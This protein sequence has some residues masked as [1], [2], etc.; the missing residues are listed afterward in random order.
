MINAALPGEYVAWTKPG[1]KRTEVD[2]AGKY[3]ASNWW[4]FPADELERL[5]A[6]LAILNNW[7]SAHSFPLN[8]FQST[9]R[10][11]ARAIYPN[12][13]VAQRIKRVP[14]I[15]LKLERFPSM[16]LSQMQDI[17]G[18][19]AIVGSVSNTMKL[20]DAYLRSQLRHTLV[21][22][23]DYIKEPKDSGY[24]GIHLVYRYLSDRQQGDHNGLQIEMQLRSHLQHAWATAVETAGT[25]LE[26][27]LKSSQG[28][29]E[30]LQFFALV[31]SGFALKEKCPPVPG[32]PKSPGEVKR[33]IK[34]QA[35]VLQVDQNLRAF[36]AAINEISEPTHKDSHF[37][38][39][40]LQPEQ[41]TVT[42]SG[43][44]IQQLVTANRTYLE[45]EK[46]LAAENVPGAQAVLVAADT[47]ESLRRAYPNF[48][49]D[50]NA[51]LD[52]L[53]EVTD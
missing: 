42:I 23:K 50:T 32:T 39:L 29:D 49:L 1:Y 34:S 19:R 14:S 22:E 15:M 41:N 17:G 47:L 25:F 21:R 18:C 51:F 35:K 40:E 48:Y 33:K 16:N 5:D 4:G 37:F 53:K 9:L 27:S 26:R 31:S 11:K 7:R 44:T 43:Y 6:S 24:R 10:K 3:L 8:T 28:P 46:R 36:G 13:I 2:A 12:A 20:R 38:L 52:Y 45:V 30:W